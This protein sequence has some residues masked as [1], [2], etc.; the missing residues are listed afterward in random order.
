MYRKKGNNLHLLE[1][2]QSNI[3]NAGLGLFAR[4]NIPFNTRLGYYKGKLLSSDSVRRVKDNSYLFMLNIGGRSYYLDA[5][6]KKYS[7]I[8]RYVN[9]VRESMVNMITYQYDKKIWYKTTRD[10]LEG[11]ELLMDYGENYEW[12]KN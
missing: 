8:L 9:G 4:V 11:D 3:P 10:I 2:R 5:K 1:V 7:N 6:N 12:K